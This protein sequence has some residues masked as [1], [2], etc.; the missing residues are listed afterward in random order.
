MQHNSFLKITFFSLISGIFLYAVH[1]GWI[2]F[3]AP[4]NKQNVTSPQTIQLNKKKVRLFF[5]H[6]ENWNHE[7]TELIWSSDDADNINALLNRWLTVMEEDGIMEKKVAVE[8]VLISHADQAYVSLNQTPFAQESTT[9]EKTMWIE[10]L[11][12]TIREN[13]IPVSA[14]WFLVRHQPL[15]DNHLDF[16]NPWPIEG[17]FYN[18]H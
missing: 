7:M 8:S 11:L 6:H 4:W 9:Y 18:K 12:K 13:Q 2:I 14:I 3:H 17:F 16:S 5:W 1:Q 15:I 10:A